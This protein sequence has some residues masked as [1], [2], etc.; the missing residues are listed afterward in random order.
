MQGKVVLVLGASS[1]IGRAI[2]KQAASLDAKVILASRSAPTL[3]KLQQELLKTGKESWVYTCDVCSEESVS[4]LVE[5]V[6]DRFKHIDIA[7]LSSGIQ[8]IDRVH[9]LDINEVDAM[10][11]TNVVGII[12]CARHILPHM[13]ERNQGQLVFIS[14]VMGEA[15][16]PQMVSYGATKAA[17]TCFARGLQRELR[18]TNVHVNLLSPGH[19]NT[20]IS[21]HLGDRI[22]HWYGKSGSLDVEETAR[23]MIQ[24]IQANKKEVIIGRQSSMLTQLTKFVPGMANRIIQK[25]TT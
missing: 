20:N 7:I 12:R 24:A 15:A 19:M 1:G 9:E 10:F 6:I 11:Q 17:I 16:F 5:N 22:P 18:H 21:A 25:I 2:A 23:K 8:F 4:E 3:K 14:S 13:L